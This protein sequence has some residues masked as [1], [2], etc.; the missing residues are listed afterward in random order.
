M[1]IE[2]PLLFT[3]IV[4]S[5]GL[6]II[7]GEALHGPELPKSVTDMF[8]VNGDTITFKQ[9]VDFVVETECLLIGSDGVIIRER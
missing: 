3:A 9:G 2:I 5:F 4:F 8:T 1:K 7:L 6:G